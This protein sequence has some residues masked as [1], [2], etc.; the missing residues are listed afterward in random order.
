MAD[1]TPNTPGPPRHL[2][3]QNAKIASN[4][5]KARLITQHKGPNTDP[6][7]GANYGKHNLTDLENAF[8]ET[9]AHSLSQ[10]Q[11]GQGVVGP[12]GSESNWLYSGFNSPLNSGYEG[13][14]NFAYQHDMQAT[15]AD[16]Q[17]RTPEEQKE[18]DKANRNSALAGM[19]VV[20]TTGDVNKALAKTQEVFRNHGFIVRQS[21]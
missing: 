21:Y 6:T 18:Y 9:H 11:A 7:P 20:Q 14:Q 19:Y 1:R 3:I 4:G 5:T 8:N 12:T 10:W 16:L 17:H 15:D 13:Y 2:A